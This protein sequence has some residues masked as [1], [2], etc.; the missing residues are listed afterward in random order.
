MIWCRGKILGKVTTGWKEQGMLSED[1]SKL[2]SCIKVGF[3]NPIRFLMDL[4]VAYDYLFCK[5]NSTTD[6]NVN[7][8][9]FLLSQY[10][11]LG[12]GFRVLTVDVISVFT[13]LRVCMRFLVRAG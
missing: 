2:V 1:C 9:G 10:S 3:L 11:G 4:C 5:I 13:W 7:A 8:A 12:L 6:C